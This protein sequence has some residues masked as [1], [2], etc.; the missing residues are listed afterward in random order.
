M[1][2]V[3]P[4]TVLKARKSLSAIS[5]FDSPEAINHLAIGEGFDGQTG[6]GRPW[7]DW[8][9]RA[10]MP[11]QPPYVPVGWFVQRLAFQAPTEES[12]HWLAQVDETAQVVLRAG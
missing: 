11:Q 6:L 12:L 5:R 7:L 4:L 1:M 2:P 10:E 3:W 8:M 9:A